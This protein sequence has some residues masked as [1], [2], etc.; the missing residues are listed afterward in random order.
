MKAVFIW[1]KFCDLM[2]AKDNLLGKLVYADK[3]F[4]KKPQ[5]LGEGLAR[6]K[7]KFGIIE[8]KEPLMCDSRLYVAKD[9]SNVHFH[10]SGSSLRIH[11]QI[12]PVTSAEY[13]KKYANELASVEK[14]YFNTNLGDEVHIGRNIDISYF[15]PV[16]DTNLTGKIASHNIDRPGVIELGYGNFNRDHYHN[17]K[18]I[19]Y[20]RACAMGLKV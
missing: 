19:P 14:Q 12:Q 1:E 3:L 4:A 10:N 6:I 8:Q 5:T 2:I 9:G 13:N 11:K 7:S 20:A 18:F 15:K 16:K 17:S